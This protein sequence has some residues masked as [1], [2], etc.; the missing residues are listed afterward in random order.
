VS[1][2]VV[3]DENELPFSQLHPNVGSQLCAEILLLPPMLRNSHEPGLV[4]GHR[5]IGANLLL[6]MMLCRLMKLQQENPKNYFIS[7]KNLA[8]WLKMAWI[9]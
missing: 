3:F 9:W 4:E 6:S 8:L 2:D 5:T 1:P 7:M